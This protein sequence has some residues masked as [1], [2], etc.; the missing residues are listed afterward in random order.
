M[1]WSKHGLSVRTLLQELQVHRT[2]SVDEHPQWLVFEAEGGIQ[3]RP[4]QY[5]IVHH[6]MNNPGAIA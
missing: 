1:I 6:L 2:W 5:W 4:Q 3:I